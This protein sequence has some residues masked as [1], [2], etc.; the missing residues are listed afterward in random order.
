MKQVTIYTSQKCPYCAMAKELLNKKG[1]SVRELRVDENPEYILQAVERSGGRQTVPQIFID[2][3]HVGGYD[4][5]SALDQEGN[6]DEL[7]GTIMR[8]GAK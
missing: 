5:L 7:L 3:F 4:E 6:L 1:V 8:D 2:D